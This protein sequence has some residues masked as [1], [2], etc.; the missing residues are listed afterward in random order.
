MSR[1]I[2][3]YISPSLYNLVLKEKKA[4]QVKEDKKVK[5]RR[6]RITMII[7]SQSIARKVR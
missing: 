5:S 3:T 2:L 4:L 6:R 1:Q 7:A